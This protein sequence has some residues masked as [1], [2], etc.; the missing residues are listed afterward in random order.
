MNEKTKNIILIASG[1][2]LSSYGLFAIGFAIYRGKPSWIF[3][4]CYIAMIILGIGCFKKDGLLMASQI[5][6][7]GFYLVF[8]NIDFYYQLIT[9]NPLWNITDFFFKELLLIARIISLEHLFLFPLSLYCLY[10]VK[11]ESKNHW[12]VSLFQG[13]LVYILTI[14]LT[15][16]TY[17]VNCAFHSCTSL[18]KTTPYYQIIWY[19]ISGSLVLSTAFIINAIPIFHKKR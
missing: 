7:V 10:L 5:N 15:N 16:Q 17:N 4:F 2:L 12:A 8:W 1:I 6:L 19:I 14:F 18:I 13:T 3:W 9:G 11:L